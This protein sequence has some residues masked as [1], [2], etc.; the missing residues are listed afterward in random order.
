MEDDNLER[1]TVNL[2]DQKIVGLPQD[3][4]TI[5]E[6]KVEIG[7]QVCLKGTNQIVTVQKINVKINE[8]II[9]DYAGYEQVNGPL[10]FFNKKNIKNLVQKNKEKGKVR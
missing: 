8:H 7:D 3:T 5:F 4:D 1:F 6:G 10:Y 2:K 9:Y